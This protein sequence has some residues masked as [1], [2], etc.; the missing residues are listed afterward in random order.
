VLHLAEAVR[1]GLG[2]D[3]HVMLELGR[4]SLRNF[5]RL[6]VSPESCEPQAFSF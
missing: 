6:T 4:R 2:G 1:A 5:E 3:T